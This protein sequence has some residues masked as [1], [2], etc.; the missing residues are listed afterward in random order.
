MLYPVDARYIFA[1]SFTGIDQAGGFHKNPHCSDTLSSKEPEKTP[2]EPRGFKAKRRPLIKNKSNHVRQTSPH[3]RD[4]HAHAADGNTPSTS[5]TVQHLKSSERLEVTDD[6]GIKRRGPGRPRKNPKLSSPS[7]SLPLPE[8]S[9]SSTTEKAGEEDNDNSD[10]VLEVIELVIHGEQRSAKKSETTEG[11]GDGEQNQNE[12]NDV[13]EMSST[14]CCMCSA[15]IDP[16][17]GQAE[18]EQPEQATASVS[19]KTYLW[20]GLY[21]DVYKTEE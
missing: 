4:E 11:V 19:N 7:S 18:D 13:N 17:P 21:S 3:L 2:R 10:T 8:L 15:P 5:A 1:V 16:S 14:H 9:S 6:N 12:E 20:A